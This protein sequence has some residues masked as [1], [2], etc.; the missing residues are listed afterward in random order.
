MGLTFGYTLATAGYLAL[1]FATVTF[2]RD[3]VA[4]AWLLLALALSILW[5]I[6][7]DA[8]AGAWDVSPELRLFLEVARNLG[9]SLYLLA[10][11]ASLHVGSNVILALRVL[12]ISLVVLAALL[13]EGVGPSFAGQSLS[14][15]YVQFGLLTSICGL[16]LTEHVFRNAPRTSRWAIKYLCFAMVVSF[17]F[18]L[19]FYARAF[20]DGVVDAPFAA[21]RG[22]V[23]VLVLPGIAL[24][25]RR[26]PN[27]SLDGVVSQ[28]TAFYTLTLSIVGVYL[29]LISV[30]GSYIQVFGGSWGDVAR[31]VF[32]AVSAVLFCVVAFSATVRAQARVYLK[33]NFFR[34]KYDHRHEWL[35]FTRTLG[36]TQLPNILERSVKAIAQ[37]VDSPGGV[38]WVEAAVQPQFLPIASWQVEVGADE[39][40]NNLEPMI[41]LMR[42]RQWVV[43]FRERQSRPQL[44]SNALVPEVFGETRWWLLVPLTSNE[45]TVG[46]VALLA[47]EVT[48][49]L[50]Y[51]DHDLLKTMGQHIATHIRQYQSEQQN[52]ERR[53]FDTYSRLSAF[54]MHDISNILAQLSMV[55]KNAETH[56][57]NPAFIDDMI[58][59]VSGSVQRMERLLG[60]LRGGD[61]KRM[62]VVSLADLVEQAA[63]RCQL[64]Q[65]VAVVSHVDTTLR[66]SVDTGRFIRIL[67]HL[68]RNAQ[69][70]TD[71]S[72]SVTIGCEAISGFGV[73]RI[74]DTGS[75]M[76][77]AF[78]NDGLFKPFQSTK[79]TKGMG[80]GA[81]Q[82]LEYVRELGGDIE[83]T[84]V[85]GAGTTMS[86][87]LPLVQSVPDV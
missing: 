39:P 1:A 72:G 74:T 34:F 30:A 2:W 15:W 12:V 29:L 66:V 17:G 43:D 78:I 68:V 35:R 54:M 60:Q 75:G 27:W 28:K 82:A 24:A 83:V 67:E 41:E 20:L 62:T 61:E 57:A 9:W 63:Q 6:S 73:I 36:D 50:N 46:F 84:S 70:A 77:A 16:V 49:S 23:L 48:P 10:V 38:L 87:L 55:V 5:T 13:A 42:K 19:F 56:K 45:H 47:P 18:D 4:W 51:E 11:L 3:R 52:V 53:Q 40:L 85:V 26:N 80:I 31:I 25:L 86:L 22:F 65:P 8:A 59:T 71:D 32:Y 69:E 64:R 14:Q 44:Y 76:S 21:A 81:F 37:L 79:G 33:K 58:S 7:V